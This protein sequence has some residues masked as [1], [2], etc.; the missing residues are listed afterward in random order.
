MRQEVKTSVWNVVRS[1]RLVETMKWEY[2][3]VIPDLV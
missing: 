3:F 1:E 2:L